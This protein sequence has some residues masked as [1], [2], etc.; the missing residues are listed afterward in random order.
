[1]TAVELAK[2]LVEQA[3]GPL[4]DAVMRSIGRDL[5]TVSCVSV[6]TDV[7]RHIGR[8]RREVRE[9]IQTTGVNVWLL[10]ESTAI[11]LARSGVLLCSTSGIFVP[12]TAADLASH[13]TE[14]Q[15]KDYLALSQQLITETAARE[16]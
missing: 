7:V 4:S 11:G 6:R 1:M 16:N 13:R 9:S 12:A 2:Q 14:T 15:L 5:G 10:D 3:A 8:R